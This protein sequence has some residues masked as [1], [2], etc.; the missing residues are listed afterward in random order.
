MTRLRA[1]IRCAAAQRQR[2]KRRRPS[3]LLPQMFWKVGSPSGERDRQ[4]RVGRFNEGARALR[5]ELV[6]TEIVDERAAAHSSPRMPRLPAC[7]TGLRARSTAYA[8]DNQLARDGG[9]VRL[10]D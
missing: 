10:S 6:E 4:G 7:A 2:L 8:L 1:I 3:K 9:N 5:G